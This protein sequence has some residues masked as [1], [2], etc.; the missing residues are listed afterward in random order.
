MSARNNQDP[1]RPR[2]H[3]T[4]PRNWLND[5]NGLVFHDGE[6]HLYYQHNPH[7]LDWGNMSW[8]HAVSRDLARWEH[9]PVVLEFKVGGDLHYFSGC[10]WHDTDNVSGLGE[11]GIGPLL[12]FYTEHQQMGEDRENR[13]QRLAL[14]YSRDRGRTFIQYPDNPVLDFS[15][16]KFGDPA[17]LY[18]D[19]RERWVL[20]LIAGEPQGH[21]CFY[22]SDN[23]L[24]WREVGCFEAPDAAPGVWEC[25]D[26]FSL[27]VDNDPDGDP[28]WILKINAVRSWDFTTATTDYF[29]GRFDGETFHWD[30]EQA[31]ESFNRGQDSSYAEVSY[32]QLTPGDDRRIQ[33][34]WQRMGSRVWR[35]WTG[36]LGLPRDLRLRR[37][38]ET[39]Q[40]IARPV[41]ELQALR[42]EPVDLFTETDPAEPGLAQLPQPAC[43]LH[44]VWP[45]SPPDG[46]IGFEIIQEGGTTLRLFLDREGGFSAVFGN[47]AP[48]VRSA[49]CDGSDDRLDLR[50]FLD[51]S[52]VEV[53]ANDG[54][55]LST[56]ITADDPV[57]VAVRWLT[58]APEQ[59]TCWPLERAVQPD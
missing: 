17:I 45:T 24:D 47:T 40:L 2:Y 42:E 37:E 33:I 39:L 59:A 38:G 53:Y 50:L 30:R 6:Y 51:A 12:F 21:V 34:P 18:D 3:F 46:D 4:A 55:L 7:G 1:S 49:P 52:V 23:L 13:R 26:L 41:E 8:G 20:V 9:L 54:V 14:A 25:P 28:W 29:L 43:E 56:V 36:L 19:D 11:N 35:P 10:G 15:L 44:L 48:L 16:R 31:F 32:T 58:Q 22:A 5:P 27:R 57:P